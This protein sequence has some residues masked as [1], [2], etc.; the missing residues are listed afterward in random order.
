MGLGGG[1]AHLGVGGLGPSGLQGSSAHPRWV[2]GNWPS[3]GS[4][5]LGLPGGAQGNGVGKLSRVAG[6]GPVRLKWPPGCFTQGPLPEFEFW[7]LQPAL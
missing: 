1:S 6:L 4:G 3:P 5:L 2:F 7:L